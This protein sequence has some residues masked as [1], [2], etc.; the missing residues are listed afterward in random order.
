V[1]VRQTVDLLRKPDFPGRI[2]EWAELMEEVRTEGDPFHV[3]FTLRQGYLDPL[4][5]MDFKILP[6]RLTRADDA[7]FAENP[8]GSGPYKYDPEKS[9]PGEEIVFVANP[10]YEA[11]PGKLGLPRIREIHFV[12]SKNP[13]EDF[14]LGRLHLLLD[15][16][17]RKLRE[18]MPGAKVQTLNN[19][20]IYFLAVNHRN[21][22]L[23]SSKG[24]LRRA[25][26]LAINREEILNKMFRYGFAS[27]HR[28]LNGPYPPGSWAYTNKPDD[29]K[30]DP[31][32]LKLAKA[33][34]A[35]AKLERGTLPRLRLIYPDG[36]PDVAGACKMIQDQVQAPEIGIELELKPVALRELRRLVEENHDYDL[37]YYHW[38]YSNEAYWLWPL[39]DPS[40][41]GPGG[42][43]F[44]GYK[45]DG[46]LASLFRET[47]TRRE[48]KEIQKLTHQ[49][50]AD[51]YEKMPFI[52]LWQLDTHYA[53]HDSLKLPGPIDPLLIFTDVDKWEKR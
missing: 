7:N 20:R 45:N 49:I 23:G 46:P 27:H 3:T 25:I 26:A 28:V 39:F 48:M 44:L 37:A 50:H 16:P 17:T 15:L 12:V 40:A 21:S 11:R 18:S 34:A 6:Q 9:K 1:D 13:V 51:L 2:P 29:L 14:Q 8:I 42:R 32:N 35:K 43:N 22:V 36:D 38:D 24:N 4:S 31:F 19:R 41:D 10:Y 5:M 52:P 53:I 47:M 30:P 33:L